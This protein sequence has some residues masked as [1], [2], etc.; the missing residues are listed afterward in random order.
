MYYPGFILFCTTGA[1]CATY[2]VHKNK[3][4][5]AILEYYKMLDKQLSILENKINDIDKSLTTH[6][7]E[8][9]QPRPHYVINSDLARLYNNCLRK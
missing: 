2:I 7:E 3:E 9:E 6:S 8:S 1:L 4:E 5:R